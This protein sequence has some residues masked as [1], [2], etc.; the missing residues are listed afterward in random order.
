MTRRTRAMAFCA[1]L[2]LVMG[3]GA[4]EGV[5]VAATF[6]LKD[7]F[8]SNRESVVAITYTLRP[9]D[10]PTG[11]EGRKVEKAL[12]GVIATA[13]GLIITSADP[14]PDPD[15][16]PRTTF[17]PV[18]FKVYLRGGR[19]VDAD[20]VGLDR[21]LNLAYLQL[22]NPPA[23]L[24]A[25]RFNT[26]ARLEV[27]DEVMVLGL[28]SREYDYAPT[29]HTGIV[30]GV[31][32]RPRHMFVMDLY[33]QDLSIG[34]LVVTRT[35]DAVG[36]VG[37]DVLREEPGP[38]RVP[39]NVLSIFG[40]VAQGQRI[41]YPMIFPYALFA[42][43]LASPPPLDAG[44]QR[45]WLGI[46]MQPLNERLIDYWKLDV[47]G[48]IIISSVVEGSP[49]EKAGLQQSDILV[50]LQGEPVNVRKD[51]DLS[52]FRRK[53]EKMGAG[54]QVT[55]GFLRLGERRD[56][57]LALGEAPKTAWTA[58]EY[59]DEDLGMTVREITIDDLQ[60]QNLDPTTRGVVVSELEQAGWAQLAG[61]QPAD[62]IQSVDGHRVDDLEGFRAQAARL[63]EEKPEATVLFVLRQ[64]ETLFI[65][66]KTPWG[67]RG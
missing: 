23:G 62:I 58:A 63:R 15:E 39:G 48:G 31:I 26:D 44:E 60:A 64:T 12:C 9:K 30:S 36:I 4:H 56:V 8:L 6:S 3:P 10:K 66:L 21:E 67:G 40:S 24:R 17:V 50:T 47:E 7:L 59:E 42:G 34:G 65:R 2:A 11:R 43:G 5:I 54:K 49:A 18:E 55:L 14:F 51:E 29:F 25:P 19:P 32:E 45:S 57:T 20:V 28:L 27:G 53:I 41:G 38:D 46:V 35:G 13:G 33:V 61:V 1:L 37:E 16:D 52:G 22:K